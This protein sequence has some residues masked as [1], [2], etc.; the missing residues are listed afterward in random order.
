[1][2]GD[3]AKPPQM[4]LKVEAAWL[5]GVW[6][7]QATGRVEVDGSTLYVQFVDPHHVVVA[8][9]EHKTVEGLI[10]TALIATGVREVLRAARA[11]S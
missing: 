10:G 8:P 7:L 1:M 3:I 4:W 9:R 6:G 2:I 5:A 11:D